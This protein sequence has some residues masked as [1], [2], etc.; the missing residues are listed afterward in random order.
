MPAER[1]GQPGD[2]M[3]SQATVIPVPGDPEE[4]RRISALFATVEGRAQEIASRLRSIESGIGPQM[5]AGRAADSFTA[6][7]AETGPDLTTL[8]ASYGAASQALA[9]YATELAAAQDAARAAQAEA[10]TA[11]EARD[12]ATT[13]EA[14]ARADAD[15]HAVEAADAQARMDAVA[16]QDAEQRRNDA[17]GRENAA[18][19]AAGEAEQALH[20][21]QQKADEAAGRR[22]A[23][24]AR[25]VR[26]LEDA[27]R[28]GI[29]TRNIAQP[30]ATVGP[31]QIMTIAT[32][33]ASTAAADAEL[34]RAGVA[35]PAAADAMVDRATARLQEIA[36]QVVAGQPMTVQQQEYVREFT[37]VAGPG[38]L[39][40]LAVLAPAGAQEGVKR[41]RAAVATSL[42]AFTDPNMRAVTDDTPLP[43]ALR[44]LLEDPFTP[45]FDEP[46]TGSSQAIA[47]RAAQYEAMSKLLAESAVPVGAEFG[48]AAGRRALEVSQAAT[49][50]LNAAPLYTYGQDPAVMAAIE[51]AGRSAA[52]VMTAVS[53]NLDA[54]QALVGDRDFRHGLLLTRHLDDSGAAALLDR[55]TARIAPTAADAKQNAEIVRDL[56]DDLAQDPYG[57]RE[58][59]PK[60]SRISDMLA[61]TVAEHVD[62]FSRSDTG[63]KTEVRPPSETADG[64]LSKLVLGGRDA[65]D[66]LTFVAAG[67]EPGEPDRD[68]IALHAAAQAYT[69]H[70]VQ[71][72]TAGE[73]DPS[74]AM[75]QAGTVMKAVNTADFRSAMQAYESADAAKSAVYENASTVAGIPLGRAVEFAAG[76]APGWV[77]DALSTVV[78]EAV[79]GLEPEATAGAKGQGALNDIVGRQE[80]D[81]NH[82][83]VSAFQEAGALPAD[84]PHLDAVTDESGRLSPLDSFR[85]DQPDPDVT[86]NDLDSHSALEEIVRRGPAGGDPEDWADALQSYRDA[87]SLGRLDVDHAN[88]EPRTPLDSEVVDRARRSDRHGDPISGPLASPM[89]VPSD[90]STPVK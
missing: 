18:R 30:A 32:P 4:A 16:A 44:I 81:I 61:T 83:I 3:N 78:D 17:V 90:T 71:L 33:P 14:A 77:G 29:E 70:Q 9:T 50:L 10:S 35:D 46:A 43:D 49:E 15:R 38:A 41:A 51:K 60:G 89:T 79:A 59:I 11:T 39:A 36:A 27:S 40:A 65:E 57:W 56:F 87:A 21:A 1:A 34:L 7:L 67:R 20:A 88:P 74:T 76:A 37:E 82:L 73:L 26:A 86:G 45:L 13:D 72:A 28:A 64:F 12:R 2:P 55:A 8:A 48:E 66:V 63:S 58:E 53:R 85:D 24:A 54:A 69:S 62:A 6:L 22:D 75:S 25:C 5:W 47:D 68:L 52:V 23:A 42:S 80:L 31:A 19:S 84:T